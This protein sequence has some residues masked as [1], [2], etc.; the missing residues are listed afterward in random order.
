MISSLKIGLHFNTA[1]LSINAIT[2]AIP[3]SGAP[4]KVWLLLYS[5]EVI[6]LGY[7]LCQKA[8]LLL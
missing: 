2:K 7:S 5:Y 4:D 8:V 3:S 1:L 6:A